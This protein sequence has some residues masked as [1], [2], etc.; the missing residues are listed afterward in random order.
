MDVI[1]LS[2]KT[3]KKVVLRF[4]KQ[5]SMLAVSGAAV[6]LVIMVALL[7][8]L[9]MPHD[10][11]SVSLTEKVQTPSFQYPFGTDPLGRC[12]LSRVIQ[13]TRTSLTAA[14]VIVSISGI[15]G[16]LLGLL[17]GYKGGG[18]DSLIMRLVDV[19]LAFPSIILAMALIV[20]MGP[21]LESVIVALTLVH[22]TGYARLVRAEVLT[23]KQAE[24]VEGA[25]ALG[26]SSSR[27]LFKYILPNVLA[28][29]LVMASLDIAHIILSMAS[30][31]FLGLGAQPPEA[32]WGAMI[33]QGRE[34]I[35]TAPYVT[36]FPGL[37]LM[38]S[39]LAFSLLGDSL[40]DYF[41][42]RLRDKV[43]E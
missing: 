4:L 30:L 5:E 18:V 25:R 13:G 15:G 19:L 35:R 27:I 36:L 29:V 7:G 38:F 9:I 6:L 24:F 2:A 10:P 41:D 33:N 26:N 11:I 22:W 20:S 16:V 42:P 23:L 31:S 39:I 34:F 40:R 12:I 3:P 37:A 1:L 8:P 43:I 28:P 14:V 17:A 21:G 32:E